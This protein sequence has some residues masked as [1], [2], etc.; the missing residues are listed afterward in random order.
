VKRRG[1]HHIG[2]ASTNYEATV[3]FYTKVM[4]WEIGW[5]DFF[6]APDGTALM[7]HVFFDTGDGSYVAFMCPTPEMSEMPNSWATDIN[8]GLGLN[9]GGVYHFAYWVD[10]VEELEQR[11]GELRE[12]GC[13][14]TE[15]VDHGWC[16]SI[17][18]NDPNGLSLEY[19]VTTRV[20][21]DDD[22]LLKTRYQPGV[23]AYQGH[24]EL[25]ER[26]ARIMGLPP[27]RLISLQADQASNAGLEDLVKAEP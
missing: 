13:E 11:Q 20:F 5:Q 6:A 19:C 14:T 25:A 16:Q 2:L 17:Y 7:R 23:P 24:P 4:G 12:R 3:D 9:F 8:S 22:K 26:D 10:S 21:N 18:F 15:I 1:V 27:E